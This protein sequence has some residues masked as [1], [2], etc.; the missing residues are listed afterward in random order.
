VPPP[1]STAVGVEG[2]SLQ[3]SLQTQ[4][5]PTPV[6]Y[7]WTKDGA[8]IPQDGEHRIFADGGSLNFTRLHRD[9]A[10]IY[11]CSASNSQ[12]KATLNITVVVECEYHSC[13]SVR[14]P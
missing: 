9:D 14:F 6:A 2:E 1:S 7:K 10:G 8:T 11:S 13:H 3:V 4:A 12:G 5:N